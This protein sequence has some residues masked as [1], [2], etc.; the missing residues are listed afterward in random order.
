M[1]IT[2]EWN[3][4]LFTSQDR[5]WQLALK[6]AI[7]YECKPEGSYGDRFTF[8]TND[9]DLIASFY[10]DELHGFGSQATGIVLKNAIPDI[11]A[12]SVTLSY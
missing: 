8:F 5:L 11:P 7:K 12:G 1:L 10:K 4:K 3:G 2:Y 6:G 9:G